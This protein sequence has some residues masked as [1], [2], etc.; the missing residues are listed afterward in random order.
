MTF[1]EIVFQIRYSDNLGTKIPR[2]DATNFQVY[3]R[4]TTDYTRRQ[5]K[6]SGDGKFI[7]NTLMKNSLDIRRKN[8][9]AFSKKRILF[10]V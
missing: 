1:R 5:M 6:K 2:D 3:G 10:I 4:R 8:I 7:L 9:L